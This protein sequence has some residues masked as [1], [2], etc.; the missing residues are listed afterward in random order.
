MCDEAPLNPLVTSCEYAYIP[1]F[2]TAPIR[3][4]PPRTARGMNVPRWTQ[5]TTSR[6]QSLKTGHFSLTDSS[7]DS[8]GVFADW[9][10]EKLDTAGDVSM[11]LIEGLV[12]SLQIGFDPKINNLLLCINKSKYLA[13]YRFSIV[14]RFHKGN[15][16]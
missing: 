6:L 4:V 1:V 11:R 16:I 15:I 12:T 5:A 9:L 13:S 8:E 14:S 7:K 2:V 10:S 3:A